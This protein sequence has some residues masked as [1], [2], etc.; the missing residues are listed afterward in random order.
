MKEII[1]EG[2][3]QGQSRL[4]NERRV[5]ECTPCLA[6]HR[7]CTSYCSGWRLGDG[8]SWVGWHGHGPKSFL[9]RCCA[10]RRR[11]VSYGLDTSEHDTAG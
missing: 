5:M 7:D 8:V 6:E 2:S 11:E 10:V 1:D 3:L 9:A 4:L